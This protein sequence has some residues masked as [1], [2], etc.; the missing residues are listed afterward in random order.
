MESQAKC[1]VFEVVHGLHVFVTYPWKVLFVFAI[2][3][4]RHLYE[5][6]KNIFTDVELL[7]FVSSN[8]SIIFY[9]Q[10]QNFYSGRVHVH[11]RRLFQNLITKVKYVT[12]K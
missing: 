8:E 12:E 9:T 3:Y 4:P 11:L 10:E 2:P 5:N 1:I 6:L 7:H